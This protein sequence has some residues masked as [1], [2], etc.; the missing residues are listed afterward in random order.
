MHDEVS[1]V[2]A[3]LANDPALAEDVA[4]VGIMCEVAEQLCEAMNINGWEID[5]V[6]SATGEPADLIKAILIGDID[7][8]LGKLAR[9][10]HRLGYRL[11]V[12]ASKG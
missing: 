11:D 5:D 12:R 9:L 7:L 10:M 3:Q 1:W 6:A 2:D 8:N 4:A